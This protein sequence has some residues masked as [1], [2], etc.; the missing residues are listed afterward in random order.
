M[1]ALPG[2]PTNEGQGVVLLN[3]R[4][5]KKGPFAFETIWIWR[6]GVALIV[7]AAGVAAGLALRAA[8]SAPSPVKGPEQVIISSAIPPAGADTAL[9]VTWVV[10]YGSSFSGEV[11]FKPAMTPNPV[12]VVPRGGKMPV[13]PRVL[14]GNSSSSLTCQTAASMA[15]Y[16]YATTGVNSVSS[17]SSPVLL[18]A[19]IGGA[20]GGG[21]NCTLPVLAF[22]Q[23]VYYQVG[24][25]AN[26]WTE[27]KRVTTLP[28]PGAPFSPDSPMRLA[29]M[30][31][32]GTTENSADTLA[33][34]VSAHAAAPFSSLF[35]I[36]D[37]S[38][39]DGSQVSACLCECEREAGLR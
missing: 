29:F 28:A 17:Y 36:G 22:N 7:I 5:T 30:G 34:I 6:G 32:L 12:E 4:A 33:H 2:S 1:A 26:G 24:D 21:L 10:P 35:L 19:T 15:N 37:L 39:A 14:W 23:S 13:N 31:D 16:T 27:V 38:Y 3:E 9:S 8:K 11:P 25:D 18:N 20:D